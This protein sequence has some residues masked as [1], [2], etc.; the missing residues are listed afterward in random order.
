MQVENFFTL[1]KS[2]EHITGKE[3]TAANDVVAAAS[4]PCGDGRGEVILIA[5]P[6]Y[7]VV[8]K[9]LMEDNEIAKLVISTIIGEEI[10]D[11]Q[12]NP[13]E[14]TT[15]KVKIKG[16][17]LSTQRLDFT[18]RIDTVKGQSV[19]L[20]EMQKDGTDEEIE[21]F[22]RYI[23]EQYLYVGEKMNKQTSKNKNKVCQIYTI[24][25]WGE[26]IAANKFPL[27]ETNPQ[28]NY[29]AK[30]NA[31]KIK[32]SRITDSLHHRSWNIQIKNLGKLPSRNEAEEL[33]AVFNQKYCTKDKHV[34]ELPMTDIPQK[35]HS[36]LNRLNKAALDPDLRRQMRAQDEFDIFLEERRAKDRAE[37]EK[38]GEAKRKKLEAQIAQ[39]DQ[40]LAQKDQDLAQKD[41][42]ITDLQ[43]QIEELKKLTKT[44]TK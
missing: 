11:L 37:G 31:I 4:V 8:F 7:D 20:V 3:A 21:R 2:V 33:L 5:N 28:S 1:K 38:K 13:Q 6:I 10:V 34:M 19:I 9:Y 39:K 17:D 44:K 35:F 42:K 36:V 25:F 18:A 15:E 30:R 16:T 26:T 12:P 32:N 23:G 41:L 14:R 40:D 22:Q 43:K 27:I 24:F 29:R